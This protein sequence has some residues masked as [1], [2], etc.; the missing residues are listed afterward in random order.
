MAEITREIV[1]DPSIIP[2]L[3]E[4]LLTLNDE[5]KEFLRKSVTE[6]DDELK[7]R[8]LEVQKE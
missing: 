8:I 2:P 6:D 7:K 4:S 3:D 1:L 5:E